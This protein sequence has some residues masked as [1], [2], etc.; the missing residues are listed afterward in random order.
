MNKMKNQNYEEELE[1]EIE[2][3]KNLILKHLKDKTKY[4]IFN[5]EVSKEEWNDH[6][7]IGK[8]LKK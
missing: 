6:W 1:K 3:I 5:K 2:R 7:N 8:E 4:W